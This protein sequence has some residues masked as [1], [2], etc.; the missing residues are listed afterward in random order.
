MCLLEEEGGSAWMREGHTSLERETHT[1]R[2]THLPLL[3]GNVAGVHGK[4]CLEGPVSVSVCE[5]E[6]ERQ[7]ECECECECIH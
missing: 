7:C 6:C 4:L 5:C 3:S 1:Q 2:E